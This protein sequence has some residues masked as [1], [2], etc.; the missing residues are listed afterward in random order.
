MFLLNWIDLFVNMDG[1]HAIHVNRLN[2]KGLHIT[3]LQ[4]ITLRLDQNRISRYK[5][6]D[7]FSQ[8][9]VVFNFFAFVSSHVKKYILC[10]W[11]KHINVTFFCIKSNSIFT[12]LLLLFKTNKKSLITKQAIFTFLLS[13]TAKSKWHLFI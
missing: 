7:I 3:L 4:V 13:S 12:I 10:C 11:Y 6:S 1:Q 8:N 5:A 2:M 9:F